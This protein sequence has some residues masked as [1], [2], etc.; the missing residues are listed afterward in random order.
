M[1]SSPQQEYEKYLHY[2]YEETDKARVRRLEK[3][4]KDKMAERS[5]YQAYYYR[6]AMAKYHRISREVAIELEELR[7]D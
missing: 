1:Y 7:G 6:P 2:L 5:D 4:V 3:E